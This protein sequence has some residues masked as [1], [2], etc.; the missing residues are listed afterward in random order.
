MQIPFP[1][2]H[3]NMYFR[4]TYNR[5]KLV[6]LINLSLDNYIININ[7]NNIDINKYYQLH[8]NN[9]I[10]EI[11]CAS[12]KI[13]VYKYLLFRCNYIYCWLNEIDMD[14]D[15][16]FSKYNINNIIEEYSEYSELDNM[17]Y[18]D[19]VSV[20]DKFFNQKSDNFELKEVIILN[21]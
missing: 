8:N 7:N 12:S 9:T 3:F 18:V 10:S 21:L 5:D 13:V 11:Y 6:S 17:L 1:F 16:Q 2:E 15:G 19:L 20:F 4:N 14:R